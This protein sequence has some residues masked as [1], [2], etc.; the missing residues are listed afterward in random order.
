MEVLLSLM[1]RFLAASGDT[2]APWTN[3]C[4]F[5]SCLCQ[6]AVLSAGKEGEAKAWAVAAQAGSLMRC[7]VSSVLCKP[8]GDTG[9]LDSRSCGAER[10]VV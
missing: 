5:L 10:E 4:F 3:T 6:A 1:C 9:H 2:G 7:P 8:H